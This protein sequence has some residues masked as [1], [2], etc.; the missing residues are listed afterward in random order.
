MALSIT[1]QQDPQKKL[2]WIFLMYDINHN[3]FID[4]KEMRKIM[5]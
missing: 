2:E 1:A 5:N 3:G 4:K